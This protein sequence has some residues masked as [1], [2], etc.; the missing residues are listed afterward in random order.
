[1]RLQAVKRSG[2]GAPTDPV[3]D[4]AL[5][6]ARLVG[7]RA[8]VREQVVSGMLLR[9]LPNGLRPWRG[10]DDLRQRLDAAHLDQRALD[11][12]FANVASEI[13]MA[14]ARD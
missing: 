2:P 5:Q 10:P 8:Y 14:H 13:A 6:I 9:F 7:H 4:L 1:M 3:G 11:Y 12:L